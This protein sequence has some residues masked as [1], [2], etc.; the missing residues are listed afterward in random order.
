MG[1]EAGVTPEAGS[2]D[3]GKGNIL[4]MSRRGGLDAGGSA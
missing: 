4:R 2:D 3:I 1:L